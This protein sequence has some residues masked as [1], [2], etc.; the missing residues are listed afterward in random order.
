MPG[1]GCHLL[2]CCVSRRQHCITMSSCES[3]LVALADCAIELLH[4]IEVVKFHGHDISE[5]VEVC[6]DSKAAYDLC[7][8]FTSAQHSRHVDRKGLRSTCPLLP[9][10]R[11]QVPKARG[12]GGGSAARQPHAGRTLSPGAYLSRTS[13]RTLVLCK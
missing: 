2:D 1:W 7:H 3:E 9:R 10:E 12:A 6:T 5:A 8:C 4:I 13:L 11:C